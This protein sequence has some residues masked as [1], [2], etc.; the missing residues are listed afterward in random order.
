[1]AEDLTAY[2]GSFTMTSEAQPWTSPYHRCIKMK[3]GGNSLIWKGDMQAYPLRGGV[4]PTVDPD[5]PFTAAG[6]VGSTSASA[7]LFNVV[8]GQAYPFFC[9]A[10]PDTMQ[11]V[12][13]I[14]E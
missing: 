8:P 3:K 10:Q 2:N 12:V 9:T 13:F 4:A 6:E 1:L 14:V 11:G 5:S 7:Y